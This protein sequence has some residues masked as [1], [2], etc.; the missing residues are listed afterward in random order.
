MSALEPQTAAVVRAEPST[1]T[2]VFWAGCG[3]GVLLHQRCTSCGCAVFDPAARC[4]ACLSTA[5]DWQQSSGT[6][7]IATWSLVWRPVNPS[8]QVPYAVAVVDVDDGYQIVTN[9][10]GC[11]HTEVRTG[12][13]V[14]VTFHAD[15]EGFTLPYFTPESP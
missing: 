10:V 12:M 1:L 4:R 5:L 2:A 8:Y 3:R 6:G 9:I 13:R 11:D 7:V 15:S 14:A